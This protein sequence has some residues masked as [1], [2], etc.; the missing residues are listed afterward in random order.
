MTEKHQYQVELPAEI[1]DSGAISVR[2]IPFGEAIDYGPLRLQYDAGSLSVREA[3]QLTV[4]HGQGVLDVIGNLVSHSERQ[5]AL[6]A[7]LELFN[8]SVAQDVRALMKAGA[9]TDV[10]AEVRI[11]ETNSQADDNGVHHLA[12]EVEKVSVVTRG[13][14]AEAGAGSKVLAVHSSEGEDQVED[15]TAPDVEQKET[16]EYASASEVDALRTMVAN[17]AAPGAVT[18]RGHQY[19]TVGEKL[20]DMIAFRRDA[21]PGAADRLTV[22]LDVGAV[23]KTGTI[24]K[25]AFPGDPGTSVGNGVAY[26]PYIPDLLKLLRD[27]RPTANL[28]SSRP[29]PREGNSVFMPAVSVGNIVDYQKPK[30][31][32]QLVSQNQEQILT[33]SPKTTIGGGQGVSI[34]AQMWTNPSYMSSVAEDLVAA[35]AEF[36]NDKIINGDRAVDTPTSGFGYNGIL[37]PAF[38]TG[39]SATTGAT[40]VPV[41]GAPAAVIPLL[42]TAWAA[43]WNGSKRAPSAAIMSANMWGALLNEVDTDGRPL[44][45]N[46]A[47]MNPAGTGNAASPAGTIRGIPVVIDDAVGD[48]DIIVSSFADAL[49]YEDSPSPAQLQLTYPDVLTTDISVFGFSALFVRRPAAFA[50]LSGITIP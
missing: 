36:M 11:D 26:D 40:D 23:D 13:A 4:D 34:Q 18:H 21:D 45:T 25:F 5:D 41:A 15:T 37:N 50:V 38:G 9:I 49:L 22:S 28:F 6:Y 8:T 29:L 32:A 20:A 39:T 17:L 35:Y 7:D 2:V 3:A 42:G 10:S 14:F 47:P 46:V 44:I 33:D 1:P 30:Q 43:V 48:T 24:L 19:N 12:G 31:G 27:G 16:M